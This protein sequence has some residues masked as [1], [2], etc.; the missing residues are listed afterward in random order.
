MLSTAGKQQK[1]SYT[2]KKIST[3]FSRNFVVPVNNLKRLICLGM[4]GR[5]GRLPSRYGR[6]YI[7]DNPTTEL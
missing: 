1:E 6:I 7:K 4:Q 5:A 3:D 2:D